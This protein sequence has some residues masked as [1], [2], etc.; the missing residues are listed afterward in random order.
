MNTLKKIPGPSTNCNTCPVRH[1][2]LFKGVPLDQLE[3]T[4]EFRENQLTAKPKEVLFHEGDDTPHAFTLFSGWVK[5]FKSLPNGK[6]QVLR[7]ALP[8]DFIGF[9]ERFDGPMTY[10]AQAISP[11]VVCAFPR[12]QMIDMFRRYP[13]LGMRMISMTANYMSLCQQYLIGA[14]SKS[15][16]ERIA[17]LLL[18]LFHRVRSSPGYDGDHDDMSVHLPL[19]QDEL[20]EATGL[21]SV[22][23]NRV[24]RELRDDQVIAY[25]KRRL[26]IIDLHALSTLAHYEFDENCS[27][28]LL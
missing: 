19:S 11:V 17:F 8:G 18:E 10:T 25:T 21:T 22:H 20:G 1:A 3:W 23:V 6:R 4:Q 24:L 14:G 26:T 2:A 9:Q 13:D 27:P 28:L 5:M 12:P 7:F 16:K 15:A